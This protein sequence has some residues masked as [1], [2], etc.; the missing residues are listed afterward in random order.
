MLN[1]FDMVTNEG[2]SR[3]EKVLLNRINRTLDK[4]G[5]NK[6]QLA[7]RLGWQPS[8]LSRILKGR[9]GLSLSDSSDITQALGYPLEA[10]LQQ[11]FDLDYYDQTHMRD[12]KNLRECIENTLYR[13]TDFKSAEDYVEKQFP[14]TIRCILGLNPNEFW[15]EGKMIKKEAYIVEAKSGEQKTMYSYKPQITIKY[16]GIN[17]GNNDTLIMGYWFAE[18]NY[19]AL[20]ICY[21]PNKDLSIEY[22]NNVKKYYKSIISD[23][24]TWNNEFD[25]QDYNFDVELKKGEI[26]S[27]VYDLEELKM[28]EATLENDLKSIFKEYN[29]MM[30]KTARSMGDIFWEFYNMIARE[31]GPKVEIEADDIKKMIE[32]DTGT[33]MKNLSAETLAIEKANE[34]CE[35]CGADTTFVNKA[36]NQYF[37]V[38]HLIP[39]KYISDDAKFNQVSNLVCLCPMCHRKLR[40]S[41]NTE[42]EKLIVNL[43]YKRKNELENDGINISLAK[44]LQIYQVE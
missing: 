15:V 21:I 23:N 25:M 12:I 24:S 7:E 40:Y 11:E 38:H 18:E 27:R 30:R 9:T 44:L 33:Y 39:L 1:E 41:E 19:L 35:L 2:T 20:S 28:D 4:N 3:N 37:E 14:R 43:Y 22:N 10:F 42:R 13:G 26:C 6:G 31:K 32:P 5:V 34:K 16:K 29:D 36:G 17:S 8:K